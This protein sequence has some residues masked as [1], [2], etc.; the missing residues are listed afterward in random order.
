MRS[1]PLLPPLKDNGQHL[2]FLPNQG[3]FVEV[4]AVQLDSIADNLDVTQINSRFIDIDSIPS[5]WARPL[6]FEIALYDADH[7]MHDCILGEWRGLLTL[8]A[9]KEQRNFP[10][11]TELIKIPDGN[12][13]DTPEFLRALRK[14]L[15]VRT[16]EAST[17]WDQ[18]YLILFD[19]NPIGMTSPTTLLCTSIDYI[20][21]ISSDIVPW[22]GGER[23]RDPYD[24]L[25]VDERASVAGW[26][27][28]FYQKHIRPLDESTIRANLDRA[29][30][31]F[32]ERLDGIPEG[33]PELSNTPLGM[34]VGI[35]TGMNFP[36]AP[37][38]Y[39]TKNLFVI[40][41][42]NA[43][44]E[45]NILQPSGSANLRV[46][47]K[48]V[49]P[50]LPFRKELLNNFDVN[51]LN[52]R[53]IFDSTPTGINVS[54]RLPSPEDGT[55]MI[56]DQEYTQQRDSDDHQIFGTPEIIEIDILPVLE[57]WPDFRMSGWKA[58]YTYCRK[59]GENTFYAEPFL[60]RDAPS[61]SC[62]L[63]N[64]ENIKSEIT[65]T[66]AHPKAMLCRS[67]SVED[68]THEEAGFLL[69][70]MQEDRPRGTQ[71]WDIGIDF[72]TSGTTVY[73]H[74]I[75]A[76][77]STPMN[78]DD[79]L[80]RITNST[81]T[82]RTP[83][84]HKEFFS[85][86]L[87]ETPFFSLFQQ[88]DHSIGKL[89]AQT[90]RLEPLLDGRIY[91][92]EN[93]I[94]EENVVSNLKWSDDSNDR[95]FT[96]AFIEQICLQCAAE[97]INNNVNLINWHFSYPLAFSENHKTHFE[98]I[99]NEATEA[100]G[101]ATGIETGTVT[102]ESESITTARYLAGHFGGFANGAVCIDIGGETSDISIWENN[103]LCWQTSI[104]FAGRTIFLDLL[105]HNPN[106]LEKF[107]V[108]EDVIPM[109]EE[110]LESGKFYS[111][112]DT[113]INEWINN[114]EDDLKRNFAVYG[115]QITDTLFIPFI[116]LGISGLLYYVGLILNYLSE[117]E[118]F[119][120]NMPNVYIGGNG[121]R[122]LHWLDNG[123]FKQDSESNRH[124]KE[125][126][127][128]ASDFNE[129]DIFTLEITP[130]PKHEA[131]AGLVDK[132]TILELTE[133][134]F[135]ILAGEDFVAGEG[136]SGEENCSWKTLLTDEEFG[137]RLK[138]RNKLP[139]I[140]KFIE[141]F[142][143]GFGKS[144]GAP[145][146][147]DPELEKNLTS[148]LNDWF[149]HQEQ[150]ALQTDKKLIIVEPIYIKAL[151][152]LLERKTKEWAKNGASP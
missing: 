9:L 79:R 119:E 117:Y 24:Y 113:W 92:G 6:L 7:P 128:A 3:D 83:N 52:R 61:V 127:I 115:G 87:E 145:L 74:D 143:A 17:T 105:K 101:E 37:K 116:A 15:P 86:R 149:R 123:N 27:N 64:T 30:R 12:S 139:Q 43:F 35:F 98:T 10:L 40:N 144:L 142:N 55:D 91:F 54:I 25:R 36:I 72:G 118:N 75:M 141:V 152:K 26:I 29:I 150:L 65:Q 56:I 80:F 125:I 94:L 99:C 66:P 38:E 51:E 122:I 114:S 71:T 138:S 147:L 110:A 121:A 39:F 1:F 73:K 20:N 22:F 49:T 63:E 5:M 104:R 112:A 107:N 111:Q 4:P 19:D 48:P 21:Y 106:F 93:Y 44:L 42:Q 67:E 96:R 109:L 108:S 85:V 135:D 28:E 131:A 129:N 76:G 50:I 34:V 89:A 77:I 88:H 137:K 14:L 2:G 81:E 90:P 68:E 41:Q 11:K 124:L 132:R 69:L 70:S 23:L 120:R 102:L 148:D 140:E 57:V 82:E 62:P 95:T 100:C 32:T 45:S 151:G 16:L 60:E 126:I 13:E 146:I 84:V 53:I 97:A 134:K 59:A 130:Q 78:F 136:V 133:K 58:N 33:Q 8:L 47:G 31:D 46:D 18:L 103:K